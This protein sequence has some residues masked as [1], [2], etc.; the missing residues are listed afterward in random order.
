MVVKFQTDGCPDYRDSRS[1]NLSVGSIV[2]IVPALSRAQQLRAW[3]T[4]LLPDPM[5]DLINA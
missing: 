1:V 3:Y 4:D 5:F 2:L